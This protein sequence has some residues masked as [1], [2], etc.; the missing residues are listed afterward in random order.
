MATYRYLVG[1]LAPSS[2]N[3]L[4]DEIPFSTVKFGHVLN[5][6]GAFTASIGLR[7]AKAT[8]TNLDPGRTAIHVERDGVIV[9]SGILWTAKASVEGAK[10]DVGGEGWWSYFR[11]RLLRITKTYAA[12]DQLFIARD[13]VNYA[14]G[15]AGGNV[16][17]V[18][19]SETCGVVRDQTWYSYERKN[20]GATVEEFAARAGGFDFAVDVAYD[21]T[22][23]IVKT[24]TL[25]YPRRGRTTLLIWELGTNLEGLAQQFDATA[26]ANQIDALG[27]GN[28]DSM[29]IASAADPG[30]LA[31]YPLLEDTVTFKDVSVPDT[32]Q[33]KAALALALQ[34][35]P[36]MTVPTLLA[37]QSGPDTAIGTFIIGDSVQVRGSDGWISIDE[38]MR[39][40]GY[41]VTVDQEGRESVS[42]ALAQESVTV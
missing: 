28:G 33:G 11:R 1:D 7:H 2:G 27:N 4:R 20:I 3:G 12:A 19:G 32:L 38:R 24:F 6:P 15:I 41:D 25:G 37:R 22:G 18:V 17:L 14:Q 34:A 13:L 42:V 16:G 30:Q 29:L 9:W 35:K 21:G 31:S 5:R 40:Q 36:Q 26:A 8:R 10:V 39:L 23:T